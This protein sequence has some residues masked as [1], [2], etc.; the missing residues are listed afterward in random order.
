M[1][2]DAIDSFGDALTYGIAL[3]AIVKLSEKKED[4]TML[5]GIVQVVCACILL[6]EIIRQQF[7]NNDQVENL[8]IFLGTSI[9]ALSV[10]IVCAIMLGI[11]SQDKNVKA[12]FWFSSIDCFANIYTIVAALIM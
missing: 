6:E 8:P 5:L 4:Q 2:G 9:V 7:D 12:A 1:M 3:Y 10:N 11:G